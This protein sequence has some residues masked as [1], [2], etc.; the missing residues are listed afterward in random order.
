MQLAEDGVPF[1]G[2]WKTTRT[3]KQEAFR[4]KESNPQWA[5]SR[6]FVEVG[7]QWDI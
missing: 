5:W 3:N 1:S 7:A 4:L 2:A 6:C